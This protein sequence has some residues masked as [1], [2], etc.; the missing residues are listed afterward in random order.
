LWSFFLF[1]N[2]SGILNCRGFP[3]ITIRF[4]SSAALSSPALSSY[5]ESLFQRHRPTAVGRDCTQNAGSNCHSPRAI[6]RGKKKATSWKLL[7]PRTL[8]SLTFM[9]G[10]SNKTCQWYP[11]LRIEEY[12][13][14]KCPHKDQYTHMLEE[15]LTGIQDKRRRFPT[16]YIQIILWP[17]NTH[18][19][20]SAHM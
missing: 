1:K 6:W 18:T 17:C 3:T 19:T 10:Q 11:P 16:S 7:L 20:F 8:K 4:S 14:L 2:Q 5:E 9:S 13:D 12:L 15:C